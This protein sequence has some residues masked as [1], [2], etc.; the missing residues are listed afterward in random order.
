MTSTARAR[1]IGHQLVR[2]LRSTAESYSRNDARTPRVGG[3]LGAS[4]IT[5]RTWVVKNETAKKR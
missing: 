1:S 5:V 2:S 3:N 4:E